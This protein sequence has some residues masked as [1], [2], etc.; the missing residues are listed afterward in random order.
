MSTQNH[1]LLFFTVFLMLFINQ[2][3]VAQQ[4]TNHLDETIDVPRGE[5]SALKLHQFLNF[6]YVVH[7]YAGYRYYAYYNSKINKI[8]I[9]IGPRKMT[10]FEKAK[11][12]FESLKDIVL[13]TT[14]LEINNF[15]LVAGINTGSNAVFEN[16]RYF[17]E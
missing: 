13:K 3:S 9:R 10:D 7:G 1:I 17:L 12:E 11:K 4:T 14:P 16:G 2:S 5:I 6:H 8:V 15:R